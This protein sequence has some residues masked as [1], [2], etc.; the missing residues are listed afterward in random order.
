MS[1]II[2]HPTRWELERLYP[3]A[4]DPML[5]TEIESIKQLIETYKEVRDSETLSK[6]IQSL[7]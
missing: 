6:I 2:D 5:S 4:N 7:V 3:K 1:P